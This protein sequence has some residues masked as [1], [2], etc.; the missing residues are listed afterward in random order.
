MKPCARRGAAGR[1]KA[2]AVF[3]LLGALAAACGYRP[4]ESAGAGERLCVLAAPNKVPDFGAVQAVLDGA[5]EELSRHAALADGDQYPC[6]RIELLRVDEVPAGVAAVSVAGS[7]KARARGTSV[8][9]VGRAW[10]ERSPGAAISRDTGDLR[11]VA[12]LQ[13]ST[14][15]LEGV[16]H[17]RGLD[18][19]ALEL[20]RDLARRVLGLP[21]PS[22]ELP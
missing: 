5:R 18:S 15:L 13:T 21:T 2:V 16:R 6:L 10:V 14:G 7:Q 4:A 3:G 8:A 20:G 11:R 1:R 17:D 12:R 19:A 9:L 22:D